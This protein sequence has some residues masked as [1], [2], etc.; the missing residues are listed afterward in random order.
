MPKARTLLKRRYDPPLL[1]EIIPSR[2]DDEPIA[3]AQSALSGLAGTGEFSLDF[4]A[5]DARL[6]FYVR[7]GSA[8]VMERVRRHLTAAYPQA[9]FKEV[10]VSDH[11]DLDP[12]WRAPGEEIACVQLRLRRGSSLP[13]ASEW[14]HSDPLGGVIAGLS[15]AEPGERIVYQ[16]VLAAAPACWA[17]CLRS[18]VATRDARTF[19]RNDSAAS[20]DILPLVGLFGIGAIAFQGYTWYQSGNVLPLVGTGAAA[21]VGLPLA[22]ALAAR[23]LAGRHP[24]PAELVEEKLS[25]P[26]FAT[27][28]RIVAYGPSGSDPRRLSALV[29]AVGRAC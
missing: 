18:K 25:H 7:A 19:Q 28:L 5:S 24:V 16:L 17:E 11:N 26:P 8:E 10:P 9:D 15:A 27:Q 4:V 3:R 22:M 6:R 23:F 29:G 14:R 21:I 12:A 20:Q 2:W 1:A 13:V